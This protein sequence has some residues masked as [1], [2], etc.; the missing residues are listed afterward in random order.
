MLISS[1]LRAHIKHTNRVLASKCNFELK[2]RE[3]TLLPQ[4]L[5]KPLVEKSLSF[6]ANLVA[7]DPPFLITERTA[8]I[9][10]S[11]RG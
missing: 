7:K 6:K 10:T 4:M 11:G 9:R 8:S 3:G 2:D 1:H 5:V